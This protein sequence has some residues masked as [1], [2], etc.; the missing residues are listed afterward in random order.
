MV[1][2][3]VLRYETPGAVNY[4]ELIKC[5]EE[6]AKHSRTSKLWL[7]CM[8]KLVFIMMLLVRAEREAEWGLH[9]HAVREMM[10]YFFAAG[11]VNY[12]R[13][14]LYYLRSMECLPRDVQAKFLRGEHVMRHHAGLWNGIW[15]DMY[16]ETTFMRYGHG[17]GGLIG[18]TLKESAVKRWALSLHICSRVLQYLHQM[19]DASDE[20][21]V[22]SHKEES[23]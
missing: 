15:S 10:P 13:Y 2:E 8:I 4:D 14:G 11:H 9:L 19:R 17:P 16:I 18:I 23:S 6:K 7:E 12:A 21:E 5:L 20:T 1:A 3:E 22:S